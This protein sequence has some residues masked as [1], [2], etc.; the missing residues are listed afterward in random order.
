[1][2][3]NTEGA[4]ERENYLMCVQ[5]DPSGHNSQQKIKLVSADSKEKSFSRSD[6]SSARKRGI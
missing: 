5:T 4:M 2:P 3:R 1:M 6:N